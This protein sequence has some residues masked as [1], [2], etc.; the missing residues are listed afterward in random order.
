MPDAA[1]S[2]QLESLAADRDVWRDV[3]KDGLATFSITYDQEAEARRLHR[4][5]IS[6]PPT[7]GPRCHVPH[8]TKSVR[9]ILDCAVIYASTVVRPQLASTASSSTSTDS[10]K[11]LKQALQHGRLPTDLLQL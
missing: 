2:G 3:C 7:A 8:L 11:Q 9:Q 4:H 1:R 10:Y 5:T 6:S